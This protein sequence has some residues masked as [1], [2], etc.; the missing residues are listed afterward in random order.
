[1]TLTEPRELRCYDY[2]NVPYDKV[3]DA[4][5]RDAAGLFQ[6]ATTTA[7]SRAQ[8]LVA[9]LRVGVG[10]L[11]IG[12]DIKIVVRSVAERLSV[13]G[14]RRVEVALGWTAA[15]GAGLFPA[16]EATLTA[17]ALSAGETQLDL[18]GRYRPP[19]GVV[20]SALDAL[21]GHRLAEASVLR[22]LQD[23]ARLINR[24]HALRDDVA[25]ARL[26]P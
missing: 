23:V 6:R 8:A 16:M 19:L 25:R 18:Y 5:E 17:Y 26:D 1:M 7:A 2:V 14:D 11:E 13:L 22:F 4:L 24:E 12:A 3:R 20:G 21:A 15:R 10:A 9:T